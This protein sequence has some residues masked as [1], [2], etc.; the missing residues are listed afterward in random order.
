MGYNRGVTD[1]ETFQTTMW[2]LIGRAKA[3]DSSALTEVVQRYRPALVTF[4]SRQGMDPNQAEDVTQDVFLTL[5]RNGVFSRVEERGGKFRSFLIGIAKNVLGNALKHD[6]AL[7]RG[8]GST[9]VSLDPLAEVA[10]PLKED[11]DHLWVINLVK[12]AMQRLS[13][14]SDRRGIPYAE[15]LRLIAEE[16]CSYERAAQLQGKSVPDV[17]NHVHRAR[18]LL[19][20]YIREEIAAYSYSAEDYESEWS[21]LQGLLKQK[22]NEG[23]K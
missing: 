20:G 13:D 5:F 23:L 15:T 18:E 8:G 21:Y 2:S 11:F 9:P 7:K 16:G 1:F 10:T 17:R 19:G 6:R 3:G 22:E 4:L 12:L 14:E